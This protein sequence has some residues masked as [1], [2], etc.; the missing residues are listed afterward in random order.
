MFPVDNSSAAATKPTLQPAGTPGFYTAGNMGLSIPPTTIGQDALNI[1][2]NELDHLVITVLGSLNKTDQT[3]VYEAIMQLIETRALLADSTS[4][5]FSVANAATANEAV[6]LGQFSFHDYGGGQS[7]SIRPD[8][9]IEQAFPAGVAA[10]NGRQTTVFGIPYPF[11]TTCIDATICLFG[12]DPPSPG[13]VGIAL[14]DNANVSITTFAASPA[15]F[16]CFVRC[17]GY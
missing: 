13:S 15:T 1:L 10:I 14:V 6:A 9:L 16:G 7:W 8:G 11:P 17:R 2:Q 4:Q 3:Q 12:A 5:N